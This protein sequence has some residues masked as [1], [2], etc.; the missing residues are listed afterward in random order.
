ML[1]IVRESQ[2][3]RQVNSTYYL[4]KY[5]KLGANRYFELEVHSVFIMQSSDGIVS[6]CVYKV[7]G[8]WW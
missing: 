6:F 5:L 2:G 7:L 3:R 1:I 4:L 8:I